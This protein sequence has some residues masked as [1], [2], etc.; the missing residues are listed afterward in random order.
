MILEKGIIPPNALFEKINP[1]ID[2]GFYHTEVYGFTPIIVE[3]STDQRKVPSENIAWPCEGLRRVSVNSFGFG[4]SNTHIVLDDAFHY[5]QDRGLTGNH[6][7]VPFPNTMVK[8]LPTSNGTPSINGTAHLSNGT[9]PTNTNGPKLLVLSAKDEKAL[10][11]MTQAYKTFHKDRIAGN[12]TKLDALAFTL[13]DRRSH[14]LWR[15]FAVVNNGTESQDVGLS[16][17]KPIRSSSETGLAFVFTG[18]GAQYVDMGWELIQYPI[19]KAMLERID[20][21]YRSLGCEW[22]IFGK[23]I[24]P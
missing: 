2:V 19:F 3:I 9:L 18:Q 14:M 1:A 17:T 6:H 7:T 12:P 15:T 13:A 20:E 16:A 24:D 10:K 21:V 11:R 23:R 22:S 8:G 5:L 4:G